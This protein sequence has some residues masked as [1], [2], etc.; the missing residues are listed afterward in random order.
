MMK[1]H[2]LVIFPHPDDEA[3]GCSGT[4]ASYTSRGI[5]VTYV[6]LTLGEMGR[7]MG[8]PFFANRETLP[9]IRKK[10]LENACEHMG[11]NDLRLFGIRDKTV[12]FEDE[13]E[14][15]IRIKDVIEEIKPSLILTFYPGYGVHPDHNACAAAVIRAVETVA[16]KNRPT[17]YCVAVAKNSVEVLGEPDV[18]NDVAE[19]LDQ[20]LAA[21]ASHQSQFHAISKKAEKDPKVRERFTKERF[22]TYQF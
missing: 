21:I 10:E 3:L 18:T 7:N 14:L 16:Q 19:Y 12:E 13:E 22:W 2:L 15:A 9:A 20:K 5:P 11:I 17:V 6:C 4:I 1:E 8:N